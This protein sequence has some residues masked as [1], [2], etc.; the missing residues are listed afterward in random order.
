MFHK[1]SAAGNE[2]RQR[3]QVCFL[4]SGVQAEVK[5][6]LR[7]VES[8]QLRDVY[9]RKLLGRRNEVADRTRVMP[10]QQVCHCADVQEEE[11]N[12]RGLQTK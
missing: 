3:H 9:G 12:T 4:G 6:Q 2:T 11:G 7:T 5:L 10:W 8:Q 1:V